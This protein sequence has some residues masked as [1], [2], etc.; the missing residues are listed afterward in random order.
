[1]VLAGDHLLGFGSSLEYVAKASQTPHCAAPHVIDG[2]HDG[3][4]KTRD[5]HGAED[6]SICACARLVAVRP[7]S[8]N[9]IDRP[10]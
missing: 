3:C 7:V 9:K 5:T 4:N 10:I 2:G 1:M 6:S 8:S